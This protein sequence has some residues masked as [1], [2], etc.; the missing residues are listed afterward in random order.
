[1]FLVFTGRVPK[2]PGGG[3]TSGW[4]KDK[5]GPGNKFIVVNGQRGTMGGEEQKAARPKGR[6][7]ENRKRK[8]VREDQ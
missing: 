4:I 6:D 2:E 7:N 1:V 5:K 3:P 8:K